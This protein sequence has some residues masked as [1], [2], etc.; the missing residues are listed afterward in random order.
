[1]ERENARRGQEQPCVIGIDPGHSGSIVVLNL[2]GEY[3]DQ[4]RLSKSTHEIRDF[5]RKYHGSAKST[6]LER[7]KYRRGDGGKGA[8]TF[9][10]EFSK[11]K[12][13]L[14]TI[15]F[16]FKL[17]MP[18]YWRTKLN[19]PIGS[20][21]AYLRDLAKTKFPN[22]KINLK[23]CDAFLIALIAKRLIQ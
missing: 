20:D 15:G 1:M 17:V 21:K 3:M 2:Q 7:V 6:V 16:A 19:V 23:N 9:G 10:Y 13:I 12:A 18:T 22:S 4:I 5:L 14:E 11:V 8:F